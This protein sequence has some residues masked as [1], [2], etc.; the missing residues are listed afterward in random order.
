MEMFRIRSYFTTPNMVDAML[1]AWHSVSLWSWLEA[2]YTRRVK[3]SA[4]CFNVMV[5]LGSRLSVSLSV[6]VALFVSV[7]LF[8]LVGVSVGG[9]IIVT[10]VLTATL[11]FAS[12]SACCFNGP[13]SRVVFVCTAMHILVVKCFWACG[14]CSTV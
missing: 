14:P 9:V 5:P 13:V 2:M 8:V 4:N 7:W 12:V 11:L 1:E 3:N 6:C 10:S